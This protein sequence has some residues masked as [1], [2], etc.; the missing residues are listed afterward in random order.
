MQ[1]PYIPRSTSGTSSSSGSGGVT[2]AE[3]AAGL[4][5]KSNLA[6]GNTFTGNQTIL[7]TLAATSLSFVNITIS[8]LLS[9][10]SAAISGLLTTNS[11]S[12]TTT[13]QFNGDVSQTA[14]SMSTTMSTVDD[15]NGNMSVGNNLSVAGTTALTG[16]LTT[17][18]INAGNHTISTTGN[19]STGT[20]SVS[21]TS[22][23]TGLVSAVT[24]TLTG[25]LTGVTATFSGLISANGGLNANNQTIQTT[26]SV[27]AGTA[28]ISTSL[29][30][31][32]ST[33]VSANTGATNLAATSINNSNALL[34]QNVSGGTAKTTSLIATTPATTSFQVTL[35]DSGGGNVSLQYAGFPISTST[36][37]ASGLIS[38][39]GGLNSGGQTIQT[40]GTLMGGNTVTGLTTISGSQPGSVS[41]TVLNLGGVD[42][43]NSVPYIQAF[44][45]GAVGQLDLNPSGGAVHTKLVTVDNGSGV[46]SFPSTMN[47]NSTVLESAGAGTI[48][49]PAATG[50]VALTSSTPTYTSLT[51]TGTSSFG[52]TMTC[53]VIDSTSISNSGT[54][55]FTGN[56]TCGA[57]T[58]SSMSSTSISNS[59][60]SSFVGS[61]TCA[62]VSSTSLVNSG[63][64][65]FVGAVTTGA[66]SSSSFACSGTSSFTG[67]MTAGALST[68]SINNSGTS[69]FTGAVTLSANTITGS[70]ATS[71]L[72]S[73]AGTLALVSQIPTS[74]SSPT[75]VGLTLTGSETVAGTLGVTSGI[76]AG[77]LNTGL[78]TIS[79]SQS[80][81]ALTGTVLGLGGVDT[82]NSVPYLQSFVSSAVG[83][84][85]LN[86]QGGAVHTKNVIVDNGSGAATFGGGITITG[87]TITNS[88][89]IVSTLPSVSNGTLALTSQIPSGI[90]TTTTLDNNS[91]PASFTSL[92][93]SGNETI[94]GSLGVTGIATLTATP[95]LSSNSITGSMATVTL[96]GTSGTLALAPTSGTVVT[97]TTLDNDTLPASFTTLTTSST[98][99]LN[100]TTIPGSSTLVTTST[101]DNNSLP[102]SFTTL[103]SS[104]TTSLNGTTIPGS[105]TL[106]TAATLNNNTLPASFTT[107]NSSGNTQLGT[108]GGSSTTKTSNS[109]L[110]DG[111]GDMTINA[112]TSSSGALNVNVSGSANGIMATMFQP[113]L[114][115]NGDVNVRIGVVNSTNNFGSITFSNVGTSSA[116][117]QFGIDVAGQPLTLYVDGS[118][119]AHTIHNTLD[120]STG[121]MT[122]ASTVTVGG[123]SVLTSGGAASLT[124]P[125][126]SG[127]LALA[128]TSGTVVTTTTLDNDT[129]PASFTTIAASGA[130]TLGSTLSA[131]GNITSSGQVFASSSGLAINNGSGSIAQLKYSPSA[132]GTQTFNLSGSGGTLA[133]TTTIDNGTLPASFT[134]LSASSTLTVGGNSV[135]SSGGAASLT[136]P[137]SSGTL[138]LTSQLPPTSALVA[139]SNGTLTGGNWSG[140]TSLNATSDW[141]NSGITWSS[142]T[143]GK[144]LITATAT[145]ALTAGAQSTVAVQTHSTTTSTTVSG[146]S[147]PGSGFQTVTSICYATS[148]GAWSLNVA[149]SGGSGT[150]GSDALMLVVQQLA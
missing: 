97:T 85:D 115:T 95:V 32:Q 58:C 16:A 21:S 40:T 129:L 123:N 42:T 94:G 18:T 66:L 48:T 90:V 7:G 27:L 126:S 31:D 19:T 61:M 56:M 99:S 57:M 39:N 76:T 75:Y 141:S 104:N 88:T 135:L 33:F 109:I 147:P 148:T 12:V 9:A 17:N 121:A 96:P 73:T 55:S 1:P 150:A 2:P 67:S 112:T 107:L 25:P 44:N 93:V 124:L 144:F 63:T 128:P 139:V 34:F 14:G 59:G 86:P 50:T 117:N 28:T 20:L 140:Y 78:T 89:G 5:T 77:S 138:A 133:T 103:T 68:T 149:L 134:T 72:P 64:S 4:A 3:L 122:V 23:F 70:S 47:L 118:G 79:G 110:D 130:V 91:L 29:S 131:T 125:A 45:A 87:N 22:S 8:G 100:G 15:S 101:V 81:T 137:P 10:A 54:S 116:S 84:L 13:T 146:L 36:L 143:A 120:D 92:A 80:A 108:L 60:T 53:G 106:V 127:T 74:S 82:L 71:T 113:S 26:G 30:V 83:Q 145:V 37:T 51:V 46:P 11:L 111:N 98:A 102:A 41:G 52:S 62:A 105:S 6:G 43:L 114:S 142:S 49:F 38:A 69:T 136:L 65:S 35:P 24:Q 132:G 119:A